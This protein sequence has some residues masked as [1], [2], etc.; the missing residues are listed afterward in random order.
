MPEPT[1]TPSNITLTPGQTYNLSDLFTYDFGTDS[2]VGYTFVE[3]DQLTS[4]ATFAGAPLVNFPPDPYYD[5]EMLGNDTSVPHGDF[6]AGTIT[7]SPNYQGRSIT[8]PYN[9]GYD[10]ISNAPV[11]GPGFLGELPA[12]FNVA[13]A[14]PT[15]TSHVNF[16]LTVPLYP[17]G[18][19]IPTYGNYGGPGYTG[20]AIGGNNFDVPPVD[21]L[22]QL[23]Q[24]HDLAYSEA[25]SAPNETAQ[26]QAKILA[27]LTLLS[28]IS[29]IAPSELDANGHQYAGLTMIAF[30]QQIN[31]I[32]PTVFDA[33]QLQSNGLTLQSMHQYV[34]A[35]A[36][37]IALS[38]HGL[39]GFEIEGYVS[40]A[41]VFADANGNGSLDFGEV[42]A[43][44]GTNGNFT[45]DIGT[46]PWVG[47]D[48]TGPMI[49]T[50]GSDVSTGLPFKGELTAP[51][52]STVI[53][54]LTTLVT[55]VGNQGEVLASLGLPAGIDL[56][57]FDPIAAAKAGSADG[58]ATELAG[59]KVYDTVEM[60]AAALAG[61]GGTFGHALQAAFASLAT[62]LEGSGINLSDKTALSGLITQVA[63][64]EN[65]SLASG[66]ADAVAS[67]IAAGNTALDHVLQV[68]QPGTTLLRDAAGVELVE[69]GAAS[70]AIT[71]AAD[72][73]SQLQAV[74]NLFTGANLDHLITQA[75][76]ETQNPGQDL[77]PIAFDGS[78]TTDQNTVLNGTVSAVDLA[79]HGITYSI[80]GTMPAGLTFK[81]DGTFTFDPGSAYKY[82]GVGESTK[83]SFQFTASDGQG[84]DGTATE[85][86]T[87]NGL[88]DNPIA[89]PDSNGVAK[90]KIVSADASHGLLANDSDPDIHDHL[91]VVALDG[92]TS[93]VGHAIKGEHGSLTVNTDG[94]YVYVANHHAH[95]DDH[96]HGPGGR[97]AYITDHDA[98]SDHHGIKQDV[99]EYTVSDGH[100]GLSTSTLSFVVFDK[101]TTYL[102]GV[103]TT[104]TAGKGPYILDG[105]AGG[106][107]L[108][109]GRGNSVLIGGSGDT[110][111]AGK[112]NDTFL[113][114]SDFG[115]NSIKNF[116]LHEDTLQVDRTTFSSVRD[117]LAHTADTALGAVISDGH[118]D[119]VTLLGVKAGQLHF[120][121]FDLV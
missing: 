22:D 82:L 11:S 41:T 48:G 88:N 38:G 44:T 78:A 91:A 110:L 113:F 47:F 9:F 79:G 54:P 27:D 105:S 57:T 52:G 17:N 35:A 111:I 55:V 90:G 16:D 118:G 99:F 68:D 97:L 14:P 58:A 66:V 104:L 93:S 61:P 103:N 43:T 51:E 1:L 33:Q 5:Y 106:D 31:Q 95:E 46:G 116:D 81:S 62:T 15:T 76:T 28:G 32:A 102:S 60:I 29:Q 26:T 98:Q 69:Q 117:I 64:T 83:L 18:P 8:I 49:A 19:Q 39:L 107:T 108:I 36:N 65:V 94:S 112:G 59:A 37:Q 2:N 75:Q 24:A 34:T 25:G 50:G 7:I 80:D 92:Q 6:F 3:F 20:G 89:V 100:G 45:L 84:T 10:I 115:T 77:G 71:N 119:M 72:S 85:T 13:N 120:H 12:T 70:T 63:H 23:F 30:I 73:P 101:G 40:G 53:T 67:I 56:T 114:R 96:Y 121:D 87:I 86:I 4:N 109:A 74:A 42:S 21:A